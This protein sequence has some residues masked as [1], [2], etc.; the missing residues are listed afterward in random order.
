MERGNES[1]LTA[2]PGER[3]YCVEYAMAFKAANDEY[4]YLLTTYH[5]QSLLWYHCHFKLK[6]TQYRFV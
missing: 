3:C 2:I 4:L 1:E 5:C 6:C